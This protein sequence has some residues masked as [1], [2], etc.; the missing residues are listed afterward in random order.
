ML[1]PHP[2]DMPIA[3]T[4]NKK[5]LRQFLMSLTS[6]A[7]L[8][9]CES[10]TLGQTAAKQPKPEQAV[11]SEPEPLTAEKCAAIKQQLEMIDCFKELKLQNA[12]VIEARKQ[13]LKD[14]NTEIVSLSKKAETARKELEERILEPER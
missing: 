10:K 9:G 13:E 8:A 7:I 5:R 6:A 1:L 4:G 3:H 11:Q 14:I 12:S 2:L